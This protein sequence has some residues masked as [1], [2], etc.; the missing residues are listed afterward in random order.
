MAR[1]NDR[2]RQRFAEGFVRAALRLERRELR[3]WLMRRLIE[4]PLAAPVDPAPFAISK[5][6]IALLMKSAGEA[7]LK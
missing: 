5:A 6:D 2:Q 3:A 7:P 4:P 1:L